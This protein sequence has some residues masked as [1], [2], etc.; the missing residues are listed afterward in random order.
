MSYDL[1]I[2][3]P[4]DPFAHAE[5]SDILSLFDAEEQDNNRH[6][7]RREWSIATQTTVWIVLYPVNRNPDADYYWGPVGTHWCVGIDTN[8]G[9]RTARAV[10]T[11][12]AIAYYALSLIP[13]TTVDDCNGGLYEDTETFLEFAG[14]IMPR[15]AAVER[16]FVKQN[17]MT[18]EG[19]PIF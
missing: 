8:G 3:F 16:D 7:D 14:R 9:G 13:G 12:F 18:E 1:R 11:Q 6:P 19:I 4:Q 15:L 17:L 2:F 5:W 10:W